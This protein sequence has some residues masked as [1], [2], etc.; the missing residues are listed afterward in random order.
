MP[1]PS[2]SHSCPGTTPKGIGIKMCGLKP[3][4]PNPG[5]WSQVP[6]RKWLEVLDQIPRNVRQ[7]TQHLHERFISI[8]GRLPGPKGLGSCLE[9][10]IQDTGCFL[11]SDTVFGLLWAVS[12]HCE[13]SCLNPRAEWSS[14]TG[15]T[16]SLGTE[17]N[18]I[19]P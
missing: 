12:L 19:Q 15:S 6:F 2:L 3:V 13:Q 14:D 4:L 8:L 10:K 7:L 11:A 18:L 17:E 5:E 1:A 9:H 16:Q